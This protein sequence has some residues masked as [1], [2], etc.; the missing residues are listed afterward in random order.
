MPC[1]AVGELLQSYCCG[2]LMWWVQQGLPPL[3]A[4]R[5]T[6]ALFW[7][8]KLGLTA[9]FYF[10]KMLLNCGWKT[11]KLVYLSFQHV[12]I[13]W[14]TELGTWYLSFRNVAFWCTDVD[15][16]TLGQGD[17]LY[18]LFYVCR[19]TDEGLLSVTLC[20]LSL[21]SERISPVLGS[22][23]LVCAYKWQEGGKIQNQ[24]KPGFGLYVCMPRCKQ[25][26]LQ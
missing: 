2:I 13:S 1:G 17:I 14:S 4:L 3:A 9:V 8:A 23:F 16:P 25:G 20:R 21:C 24:G 19:D 10:R 15:L 26:P 12:A 5:A 22:C 7:D 11:N 18:H 6:A